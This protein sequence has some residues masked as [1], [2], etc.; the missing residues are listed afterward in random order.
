MS[1]TQG[2]SYVRERGQS[3]SNRSWYRAWGEMV[4]HLARVESAAT[5]PLNRIHLPEQIGTAVKPRARGMYYPVELAIEDELTGEV[6]FHTW[7]VR[8]RAPISVG[9]ILSQAVLSWQDAKQRGRGTPPGRALGGI[10]TDAIE[11]VAP[12]GQPRFSSGIDIPGD[13]E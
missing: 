6:S 10:V 12:G 4:A 11:F 8:S 1:A 7:G 9:N 3:I 5:V 13:D 2:L